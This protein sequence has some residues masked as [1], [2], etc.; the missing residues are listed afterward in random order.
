M[1]TQAWVGNVMATG[2][3]DACC[4]IDMVF[5]KPGTTVNIATLRVLGSD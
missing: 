2:F 1:K 5:L 3:W 4:V